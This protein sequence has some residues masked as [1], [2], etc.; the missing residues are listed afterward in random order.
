MYVTPMQIELHREGLLMV[1]N[2]GVKNAPS[3]YSDYTGGKVINSKQAYEEAVR[4]AGLGT[5]VQ[6]D[7]AG[8]IEYDSP[9]MQGKVRWYPV[10]RSLG[11]KYSHQSKHRDLYGFVESQGKML[12]NSAVITM[13]LM[14]ANYFFALAFPGGSSL[15]PDGVTI[16]NSAH[17]QT[18]TLTQS[19]FGTNPVSYLALEDGIQKIRGQVGDRG[20]PRYIQGGWN[21]MCTYANEGACQR[22][23]YSS[24]ISGSNANDTSK[25]VNTNIK[26]VTADPFVGVNDSTLLSCWT[27]I[28]SDK[29]ENPFAY[30]SAEGVR[31]TSWYDGET[32][33][34]KFAAHMEGVMLSTG[35]LGTFGSHP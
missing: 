12:A 9:V 25:F 32:D 18:G 26:K 35:Y 13:N 20:L 16:F 30:L 33:T 29:E 31:T 4:H 23:V 27:L 22:A 34:L 2:N 5:F 14:G 28:P 3:T 24:Q 8:L 6:R 10:L 21:L 1:I 11:I 15:T 17:P 7:E 19:N